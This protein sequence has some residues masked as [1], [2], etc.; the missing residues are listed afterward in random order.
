[1][2]ILWVNFFNNVIKSLL[3]KYEK[4]PDS[5]SDRY[6]ANWKHCLGSDHTFKHTVEFLQSSLYRSRVAVRALILQAMRPTAL[7]SGYFS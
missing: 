5:G 7:T 2:K 3:V 4:Q 6:A 1:M